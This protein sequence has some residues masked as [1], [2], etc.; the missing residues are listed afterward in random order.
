MRGFSAC[1]RCGVPLP[2]YGPEL[3]A[4]CA[5]AAQPVTVVRRRE[6]R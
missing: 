6:R 3:C 2:M 1:A 4:A 5:A